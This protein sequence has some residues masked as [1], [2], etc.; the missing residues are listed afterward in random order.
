M[1]QKTRNFYKIARG[2]LAS[3]FAALLISTSPLLA[4]NSATITLKS[5]DGSLNMTGELK[6]VKDGYYYIL[7]PSMGQLRIEAKNV[8]CEGV[9][10]P[11]L[12][13][14]EPYFGIY[15]SRTVGTNLIPNLMRGYAKH[16]GASFEIIATADPAERIMRLNNPDGSLRLEVDLQSRGSGTAFPALVDGSAAIGVADRRM[17]DSDLAKLQAAGIAELR[18]TSN[19]TVVGV[20]GIVVIL[21]PDN[22]VRNLSTLEIAQIWSGEI[23]NWLELGGGNYPINIQ[24]FGKNSGDRGILLD[25]VVR[26]HGRDETLNVAENKSYQG[27]VDAVIADRGGIG[28]VGRSFAHGVRRLTIREDCGLLSPPTDF[29]IKIEG[30]ALSRRLYMY[31]KPGS[32]HPEARAFIDWSLTDEAQP[33]IEESGFVGRG[34]DRMRL[35]DMGMMLI[36]TAAVEP[37][38]NPGQYVNMMR[39]LRNTDR[40]SISFRFKTGSSTLDVESVRNLEELAERMELG[41]FDGTEV[42]LIGF[43][44][45]VGNQVQNTQLAQSRAL[46]V[47]KEMERVLS[48]QALSKLKLIPLSYGELLPLSCNGNDLGRA[49]NRRV[50]VWLRIPNSRTNLR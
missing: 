8:I 43:A 23:T 7:V 46:A 28:F 22:P 17:K 2:V 31:T 45:S 40:L 18:D 44:D 10:C 9:V 29:R 15:G 11:V 37:D 30:Y 38:F 47:R 48:P 26:P 49:R 25:R 36:H 35:E 21:H 20:D 33:Y 14:F 32:L 3:A 19:E 41:Q 13:D 34:L 4:Q 27:M 24:S 1:K 50:E 16:V 6:E 12:E 39:E 42:L 5:L